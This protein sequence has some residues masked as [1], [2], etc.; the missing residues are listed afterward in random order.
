MA[1]FGDQ[2][3]AFAMEAKGVQDAALREAIIEIGQRTIDRSPIKTGRFRSNFR[4][5][6]ET[7][8][9]FTTQVTNEPYVHN[10]EELPKAPS[11]F[12]HWISNAL[13]YG[14]ALERGSSRQA[15]SGMFGLT[16]MEWPSIVAEAV[17][18]VAR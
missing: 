2:V 17:A 1:K 13:P 10:L 15:P 9:A 16:S 12:T 8:D 3:K 5:G 7:R 11:G 14:P 6:L 18:K 4:Y